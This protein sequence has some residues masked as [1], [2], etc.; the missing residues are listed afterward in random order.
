MGKLRVEDFPK[1]AQM[2][3]IYITPGD[4]LVYSCGVY[5]HHGIYCG[6]ISYRNK[7]YK[8][9]VIH[10][11]GKHKR[12]QIRGISYEKFAQGREVYVISYKEEACFPACLVV[13][14]AINRLG[15]PD[16]NL[17]GN[18]CE[19]F[20]H[21]CKTGKKTSSQVN[22]AVKL[23]TGGMGTLGSTLV[24]GLVVDCLP[25]FAIPGVAGIALAVAV[26]GAV[27]GAV[28][29]GGFKLGEMAGEFFTDS[30]HYQ[31]I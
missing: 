27:G 20:A 14:R 24:A 12:G 19:H 1:K 4:H 10:Y 29:Y 25:L 18:N 30:A 28:G 17:F 13:N 6:D 8:D 31:D 7:N 22:D 3:S 9:V 15:E 11:E 23:V 2:N 26:G 21:W 16:Y 5:S